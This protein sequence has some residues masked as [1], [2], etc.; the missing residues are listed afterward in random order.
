MLSILPLPSSKRTTLNIL[1]D[2]SGS[3]KPGRFVVC[4]LSTCIFKHICQFCLH[5]SLEIRKCSLWKSL[6]HVICW[7]PIPSWH[8]WSRGISF[9]GDLQNDTTSWTT[10]C[11]EDNLLVSIVRQIGQNSEGWISFDLAA[12]SRF[13]SVNPFLRSWK[14]LLIT[15]S[16]IE[17]NCVR[18][19][20]WSGCL[21]CKECNNNKIWQL[22][23]IWW[24]N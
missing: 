13:L 15:S 10:R 5:I 11:G 17:M 23:N 1:S 4:F 8:C 14:P 18:F 24:R 7:H 3:I 19:R 6:S 22:L 20:F 9:A 21:Y 16:A 12:S 2:V